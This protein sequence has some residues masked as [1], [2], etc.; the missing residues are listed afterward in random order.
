MTVVAVSSVGLSAAVSD[1]KKTLPMMVLLRHGLHGSRRAD[2]RERGGRLPRP[3]AGQLLHTGRRDSN[4][5]AAGK[6]GDPAH[7]EQRP[8]DGGADGAREMLASFRPI[9][10]DAQQR[11]TRPRKVLD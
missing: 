6:R 11:P 4:R 10:A 2:L 1:S 7:R 8:A 3:E 5:P 9:E